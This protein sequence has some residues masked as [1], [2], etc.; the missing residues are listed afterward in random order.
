MDPVN[1]PDPSVLPD[2][3]VLREILATVKR[4]EA[5]LKDHQE[6]V[7]KLEKDVDTLNKQVYDL[8]NIIN[9]REQQL[10][11]KTVRITGIPFTEEEKSSVDP[12]YLAKKVHEKLLSPNLNHAKTSGQIDRIPTHATAVETCFRVRARP[13]PSFSSSPTNRPG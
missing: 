1:L 6:R 5:T 4:T 7:V 9:L 12:K 8:Q 11:S 10:R 13:P 3:M 2:S